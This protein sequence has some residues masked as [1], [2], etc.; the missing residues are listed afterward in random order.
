VALSA[1][2]LAGAALAP[3]EVADTAAVRELLVAYATTTR[4]PYVGHLDEAAAYRT[5]RMLPTP[6]EL[7]VMPAAVALARDAAG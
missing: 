3:H 2:I 6:E 4:T 5:T 1:L 7:R